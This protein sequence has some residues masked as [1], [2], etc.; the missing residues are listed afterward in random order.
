VVVSIDIQNCPESIMDFHHHVFV[1][2]TIRECT[3]VITFGA[4][5]KKMTLRVLNQSESA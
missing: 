3:W 5:V 1:I 2:K 4:W